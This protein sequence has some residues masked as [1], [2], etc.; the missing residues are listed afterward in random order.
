MH[1]IKVIRSKE[2]K[3]AKVVE[4]TLP[5]LERGGY[6][7]HGH[8]LAV[9]DGSSVYYIIRQGGNYG[10]RNIRDL[11]SGSVPAWNNHVKTSVQGVIRSL[12]Q[13]SVWTV[14]GFKSFNDMI[15]YYN[16]NFRS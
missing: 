14:Y 11:V 15:D 8:F 7:E 1:I 5:Q 3:E 9:F 13:H 12:L 16:D 4:V 2:E 6:P 10:I